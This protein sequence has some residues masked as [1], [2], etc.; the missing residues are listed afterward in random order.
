M[1]D[2]IPFDSTWMILPSPLT[3]SR[4]YGNLVR[5]EPAHA[6]NSTSLLRAMEDPDTPTVGEEGVMSESDHGQ[7]VDTEDSTSTIDE[8]EASATSQVADAETMESLRLQVKQLEEALT[9][10]EAN[11]EHRVHWADTKNRQFVSELAAVRQ[12]L[13]KEKQITE[14][15]ERVVVQLQM[16]LTTRDEQLRTTQDLNLSVRVE[17]LEAEKRDLVMIV[18]KRQQEIDRLTEQSEG[19][20]EQTQAL[21]LELRAANNRITELE[22]ET[23]KDKLLLSGKDQEITQARKTSEWLNAELKQKSEEFLSYRLEKTAQ[24][25]EA[26]SQLDNAIE[27]KSSLESK[28]RVLQQRAEGLE[29][30]VQ[31][32]LQKLNES[33]TR[34]VMN[35]QQ[36]KKE[37]D[38]Q[39]RLNELYENN[40]KEGQSHMQEMQKTLTEAQEDWETTKD[41]LEEK[42]RQ[43]EGESSHWRE[44]F[45]R[46]YEETDRLRHQAKEADDTRTSTDEA[47]F[48]RSSQGSR[49]MLRGMTYTTLYASYEEEKQQRLE[50]ER[51]LEITRERFAEAYERLEHLS[52][53][54]QDLEKESRQLQVRYD[55]LFT[56]LS[57]ALEDKKTAVARCVQAEAERAKQA[58]ELKMMEQ[59]VRDLSRQVRIFCIQLQQT[60][61]GTWEDTERYLQELTAR[62]GA[63][64]EVD[65]APT[66]ALI[67]QRLVEVTSLEGLVQQNV[68]LRRLARSLARQFEECQQKLEQQRSEFVTTE[69]EQARTRIQELEENAEKMA[70]QLRYVVKQRNDLRAVLEGKANGIQVSPAKSSAGRP[71]TPLGNS[72]SDGMLAE[73]EYE[74]LYRELQRDHDNLIKESG[75]STK[76]LSNQVDK[77]RQERSD[78]A[79]QVAKLNHQIN[80]QNERYQLL[81]TNAD[82]Q[83]REIS[84]LRERLANMA[85]AATQQ[86]AK[87]Q[88]LTNGLMSERL[89]AEQLSSQIQQLKIEREVWEASK[90]RAVRES[91]DLLTERN[92]ANERARA[93]QRQLEDREDNW[94]TERKRLEDKL[95]AAERE[96]A[97]VRKQLQDASE[98]NRAILA[99]KDTE[100][101][102]TQSKVER[103]TAEC[104]KVKGELMLSRNKEENLAQ[105]LAEITDRLT[106]AEA[107]LLS[108]EGR[109]GGESTP[110]TA[111]K[112]VR[113][114]EKELADARR[115]IMRLQEDVQMSKEREA[116]LKELA[117]ASEQQ[118]LE[119]NET[120]DTYKAAKEKEIGELEERLRDVDNAR[121]E[122]LE[123]MKNTDRELIESREKTEAQRHEFEQ[124]IRT[125]EAQIETI[126]KTEEAAIKSQEEMQ[127]D[128][129]RHAR[130]A[131]QAKESY[132]REVVAHSSALQAVQQLKAQFEK[133]KADLGEAQQRSTLA[134][135]ELQ[136]ASKS[137]DDTKKQLE[138]QIEEA[139]RRMEDLQAQNEL[140]HSQF[141]RM[142]EGQKVSDSVMEGG[143]GQTDDAERIIRELRELVKY[144]RNER[145]ILRTKLD[146]ATSENNRFKMELQH[147]QSTL[148]ETR[149]RL[150]EERRRSQDALQD[151]RRHKELMDKIEQANLL[152][153]SNVTL[154]DQVE[155]SAKKVKDLEEKLKESVKE[156]EPLRE[157]VVTLQAEVEVRKDENAS[158]TEDNKRWKDRVDQILRK[159]QR[160]DP[161]DYDTLKQD[162]EKLTKEKDELTETKNQCETQK[163]QF[164]AKVKELEDKNKRFLEIARKQKEAL[165]VRS[166]QL[167]EMTTKLNE[168]SGKEAQMAEKDKEIASLKEQLANP[169]KNEQFLAMKA[170]MDK[171]RSDIIQQA[172]STLAK[173]K[174]RNNSLKD[175]LKTVKQ[176][177]ATLQQQL[178][179]LQ[180]EVAQL[181]D[182]SLTKNDAVPERV[183]QL[184]QQLAQIQSESD[185]RVAAALDEWKSKNTGEM[186]ALKLRKQLLESQLASEKRRVGT[187]NEKIKGLEEGLASA[188]AGTAPPQVLEGNQIGGKRQR[189]EEDENVVEPQTQGEEGVVA[190]ALVE[191]GTP[192]VKEP[193]GS[194]G[195]DIPAAK[196]AR[197]EVIETQSIEAAVIPEVTSEP[198]EMGTASAMTGEALKQEMIATTEEVLDTAM[199]PDNSVQDL[200]PESRPNVEITPP[201]TVSIIKEAI[202]PEAA[203]AITHLPGASTPAQTSIVE[204]IVTEETGAEIAVETKL[205]VAV[206]DAEEILEDVTTEEAGNLIVGDEEGE[207]QEG[208]NVEEPEGEEVLH[209]E[210]E[211][212]GVTEGEVIETEGPQVEDVTD[213][214]AAAGTEEIEQATG[215]VEE[216]PEVVPSVTTGERE[217]P[218]NGD[219]TITAETQS[220][221]ISDSGLVESTGTVTPVELP[222][223]VETVP[224]PTTSIP[225]TELNVAAPE[226][227]P[228]QPPPAAGT[229]TAT[230]TT[231]ASTSI[232]NPE[233]PAYR[234]ALLKRKLQAAQMEVAAAAIA[235]STSSVAPRSGSAQ[236]IEGGP[237]KL[238][239][240]TPAVGLVTE[241]PTSTPGTNGQDVNAATETPT[242]PTRGRGRGVRRA[243]RFRGG[244]PATGAR[245]RGVRGRGAKAK[246]QK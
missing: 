23:M 67:S 110:E 192:L 3:Y 102:G 244:S 146:I 99:R 129:K 229:V 170:E 112:R 212:T 80:F 82:M 232:P 1:G 53:Y 191:A 142:Q 70:R 18:S 45:D 228:A 226:F 177:N 207:I 234:M 238:L 161:H 9:V 237:R 117:N 68:D 136:T 14:E 184:E 33:E 85:N 181:K 106:L 145:D 131:Q 190:P 121:N 97:L 74:R 235:T 12:E 135:S 22:S 208:V 27:E 126:K 140:L 215:I 139:R 75:T 216:E 48:G 7:N 186:E 114:L 165:D 76:E 66:D 155:Q 211:M 159:Y 41:E 15:K 148:D 105:R 35:E 218:N 202:P 40:I 123:Q 29:Q 50:I 57:R 54:V 59:D 81:A 109:E 100:V 246:E 183:Q 96:L 223:T 166:K 201:V 204:E 169:E 167:L 175:E 46:L 233:D 180:Q 91:Q 60:K 90:D 224:V 38:A 220:P 158:L 163:E 156:L 69:I 154:R 157:Q 44:Q 107:K 240:T 52:P 83:S 72:R 160:I 63:G 56:D 124:R 108:Y 199:S 185:R 196:K 239:R 153:E 144:A 47:N 141:E 195:D 152:R 73:S 227:I 101:R 98:E 39:K 213:E 92:L 84:Q 79:I 13:A 128:V 118:L 162:V 230:I 127:E 120:Y 89:R 236:P 31:E 168:W 25:S 134:E 10:A 225:A 231:A 217:E 77:L 88:E 28:N 42:I 219:A 21:R 245:G 149:A 32:L 43:L 24:I 61:S 8:E 188:T 86:D 151:D 138:E 87:T 205:N 16:E 116:N 78:L 243:A 133:V 122:I 187:L 171:R 164:A 132:E 20:Q 11:F 150:D 210:E 49:L 178:T 137:W 197:V 5:L 147:L 222:T 4:L 58:E 26:Q 221:S 17:T 242:T 203:E 130:I 209:E 34:L 189:E 193:I 172:N 182:S 64:E 95:D 65:E 198:V 36:F 30:K 6:R 214:I 55:K 111:E 51:E 113:D 119:F 37:M 194:S 125:L 2:W 94:R 200:T 176:E 174:E 104:E 241:T 93:V 206:D 71:E 173:F 115:Q 19:L 103:L 179:V 143:Q 62:F